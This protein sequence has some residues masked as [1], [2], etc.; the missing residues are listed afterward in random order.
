[1]KMLSAVYMKILSNYVQ[2]LFQLVCLLIYQLLLYFYL[3]TSIIFLST[4]LIIGHRL[5]LRKYHTHLLR[6]EKSA[7]GL[8]T[9]DYAECY[10]YSISNI[11]IS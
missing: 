7:D 8:N 2:L 6:I 9:T 11:E 3:R 4:I 1:M 5:S 10:T